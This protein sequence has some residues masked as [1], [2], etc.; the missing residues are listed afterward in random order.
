MLVAALILTGL[1]ARQNGGM[2]CYAHVMQDTFSELVGDWPCKFL[3]GGV[4]IDADFWIYEDLPLALFQKAKKQRLIQ[5]IEI[6]PNTP[7]PAPLPQ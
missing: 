4:D 5:F 3:S 6:S 1:A 7:E 2:D